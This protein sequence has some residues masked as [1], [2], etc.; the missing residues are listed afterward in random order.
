MADFLNAPINA[1]NLNAG[2]LFLSFCSAIFLF[3]VNRWADSPRSAL[4][5][6]S[7]QQFCGFWS[8]AESSGFE[9]IPGNIFFSAFP[10]QLFG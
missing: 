3:A 6:A 7:P 5:G 10:S 4:Q 8:H 2:V 9:K 1:P